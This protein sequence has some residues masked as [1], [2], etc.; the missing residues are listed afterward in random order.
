M[1]KIPPVI[2]FPYIFQFFQ[3]HV[4]CFL[5]TGK[6]SAFQACFS[7]REPGTR[8]H[9]PTG[10]RLPLY[11][12]A[13]LLFSAHF[14]R[15]VV[16]EDTFY[17]RPM[18]RFSWNYAVN[19][20]SA[21]LF[22]GRCCSTSALLLSAQF[23]RFFGAWGCYPAH[24]LLREA[25]P[26]WLLFSTHF[27]R[28]PAAMGIGIPRTFCPRPAKLGIVIGGTIWFFGFRRNSKPWVVIQHIFSPQSFLRSSRENIVIHSTILP[29]PVLLRFPP[30]AGRFF[31]EV[32][33]F[34]AQ[35]AG[36]PAVQFNGISSFCCKL[37][38]VV[39]HGTVSSFAVVKRSTI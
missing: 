14:F 1:A 2:Y 6:S 30:A 13:L 12:G 19:N 10:R 11:I 24:I 4:L 7:A 28:D 22:Y 17:L 34:A 33:L 8:I 27:V 20:N 16:I 38:P 25:A 29:P 23:G 18:V 15:R 37:H 35:F 26:Y 31:A 3:F 21:P 36:I 5:C 32:L 9:N 39:I